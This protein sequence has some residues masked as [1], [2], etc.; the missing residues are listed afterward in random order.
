MSAWTHIGT[1]ATST[2]T[3]TGLNFTNAAIS[4]SPTGWQVGKE[5]WDS[6]DREKLMT[7]D[8]Q[9]IYG[10]YMSSDPVERDKY[11][12]LPHLIQIGGNGLVTPGLDFCF[13]DCPD[14]LDEE[15]TCICARCQCNGGPHPDEITQRY[16]QRYKAL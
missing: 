9:R 13:C 16:E 6:H 12:K 5:I 4:Y 8:P 14:C 1:Y 2:T 15:E 3:A 10:S 11:G 7:V